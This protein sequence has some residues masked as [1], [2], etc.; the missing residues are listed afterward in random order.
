MVMLHATFL[1]FPANLDSILE[2]TR[3]LRAP[4]DLAY[5]NCKLLVESVHE[6]KMVEDVTQAMINARAEHFVQVCRSDTWP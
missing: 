6:G 1:S 4:K 2:V 3:R 5:Q